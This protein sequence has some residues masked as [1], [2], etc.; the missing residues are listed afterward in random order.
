MFGFI[1]FYVVTRFSV[2]NRSPSPTPFIY[3]KDV[4]GVRVVLKKNRGLGRGHSGSH[5][6]RFVRPSESTGVS[7]VLRGWEWG[8][9]SGGPVCEVYFEFSP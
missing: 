5:Y 1:V 8:M 4:M 2:F 9:G 7:S 6:H 3:L